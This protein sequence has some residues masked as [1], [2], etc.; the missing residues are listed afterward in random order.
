MKKILKAFKN[1]P[2]AAIK[3]PILANISDTVV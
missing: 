1:G 2:I 3:P